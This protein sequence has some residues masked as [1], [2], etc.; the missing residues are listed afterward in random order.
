MD[1]FGWRNPPGRGAVAVPGSVL[2]AFQKAALDSADG[3]VPHLR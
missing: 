2:V 1:S 3:R